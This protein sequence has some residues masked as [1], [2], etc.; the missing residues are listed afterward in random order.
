MN[1]KSFLEKS[2]IGLLASVPFLAFLGCGDDDDDDNN[3]D[4]P[5][6]TPTEAD[7][8]ENGTDA[9]IGSNHGHS[10]TVSKED[11]TAGTA[12][13]YDI[14]GSANHTHSVTVS[15]ADFTT[16]QSNDS[17]TATSTD[18]S[19]HNHPVTVSCA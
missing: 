9:A 2:L 4:A 3:D 17:I 13:T 15:A 18:G 5:D 7:C 12:Q 1:R 8:G 19:G 11:V 14:T 6:E 16:L 10:L